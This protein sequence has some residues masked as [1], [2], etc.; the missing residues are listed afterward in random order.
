MKIT[1]KMRLDWLNKITISSR[2]S[3]LWPEFGGKGVRLYPRQ[4]EL[5]P[6]FSAKTLRQAI[7]AAIRAG[8]NKI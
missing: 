4:G 2:N 8:R 1:D 3:V 6:T 7:D 5:N